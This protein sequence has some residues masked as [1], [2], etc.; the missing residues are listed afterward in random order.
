MISVLICSINPVLLH[1]VI[2][3]ITDTIGT[4]FEIIHF[5]NRAAR[6]SICEVYNELAF[7]ANYQYLCF[8]HEDVLFTTHGWGAIINETFLRYTDIGLIGI[9]GSKYKSKY[10][11]GWFSGAKA[12]DCARYIHQYRHAI[13]YVEFS[14]DDTRTLQE[15]VCIDGVLMCCT[16]EI[17]RTTPFNADLL[18]GFHFYDID[19]SLRIA[20]NHTV[21]VT[22]EI[23]LTHITG[24]GDYGNN[25][26][27]EA[28]NFHQAM[29]NKLPYS[30]I[31][32]DAWTVD[33]KVVK[34][35]LDF[36]KNYNISLK[37]KVKW[38]S[39]QKL[40]L[41]SVF[42]YSILKFFLYRPLRLR[43]IHNLFRQK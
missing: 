20:R 2:N 8:L 4:E 9:A 7:K 43:Y 18:K 12:L 30:K 11:S 40:Y 21:A 32:V 13:E 5:D 6:K 15:V 39:T 33:Q 31:P 35:A 25:W 28:I 34:S 19:L 16:K 41:H 26:I 37:N 27:A 3:N 24:G 29:D 10:C 36:L 42:Y 1:Q 17:M 23:E 22:Y 14:P 38:I